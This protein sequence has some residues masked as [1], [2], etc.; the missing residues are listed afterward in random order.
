M[1]AANELSRRAHLAVSRNQTLPTKTRYAAQLA[2]SNP[3][4]F[5][6]NARPVSV[7]DRCIDTNKG[8]G[9]LSKQGLCRV[10]V[11]GRPMC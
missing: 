10:R 1:V 6:T 5:P 9:V 2:L 3:K 11:T 4:V 8:R 7:S